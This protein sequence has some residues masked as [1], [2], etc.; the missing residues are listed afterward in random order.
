MSKGWYVVQVYAGYESKVE[1]FVRKVIEDGEFEDTLLDVKV[2]AEDVV[3]VKEGKRK[4]SSK[5]F[6]PGYILVEMSLPSTGWGAVCSRLRSIQGV[7]GFVGATSGKRP[8]PISQ[9]EAREIF[10]KAGDIKSER[11]LKPKQSFVVG[12]QVRI[13]DGPFVTFSGSIEDVNVE[14]GKLKVMVGIFGRSTPVEVGFLQV[15]RV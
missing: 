7:S 9:D 10:Q 8:T 6:L 13:I 2:P 12:E 4:V 14:R 11:V 3:E 1:K 5:K 15:E